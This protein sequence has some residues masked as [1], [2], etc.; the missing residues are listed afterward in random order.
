MRI[1]ASARGKR[2][3]AKATQHA[4]ATWQKQRAATQCASLST[5]IPATVIPGRA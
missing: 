2:N 3:T 5:V 1:S 4:K